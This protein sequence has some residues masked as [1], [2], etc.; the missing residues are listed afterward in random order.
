ML[1]DLDKRQKRMRDLLSKNKIAINDGLLSKIK[2][3]S[4][5][6]ELIKDYLKL[7]LIENL[8]AHYP[9]K[10]FNFSEDILNSFSVE[11]QNLPN[12]TPNGL[13]LP[14]RENIISYNLFHSLVANQFKEIGIW[15]EI[16]KI[17]YPINIRLQVGPDA[18][19]DARPRS[20]T[21][22]HCDIWAGDTGFSVFLAI[23]GD[24]T[25]SG[26]EFYMPKQFDEQYAK[27]LDDF[28]LGGPI[29]EGAVE[30]DKFDS[31]GWF[32]ADSHLL[33]KTIKKEGGIRISIDFRF[34]PKNK[35]ETDFQE[36]AGRSRY[37]IN[38]DVW[39]QIGKDKL[40]HTSDCFNT[41]RQGQE[42]YTTGYPVDIHLINLLSHE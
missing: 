22:P 20:S 35:L 7:F 37:F 19:K 21:K 2:L 29:M 25:K 40:L 32:I 38:K 26:I 34:I 11:I 6:S 27:I 4:R 8:K 41:I 24:T 23:L 9:E 28:S 13:I 39:V 18:V 31:S 5:K 12:I 42:K 3:S 17:Q 30:L 15:D 36:D 33:H 16:E 14:K 1:I 10:D